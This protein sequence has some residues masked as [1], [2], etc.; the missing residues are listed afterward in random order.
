MA[1]SNAIRMGKA[2]V[3]IHGELNP[4]KKDLKGGEGLLKGFGEKVSRIGETLAKAGGAALGVEGIVGLLE[5]LNTGA[6]SG[7]TLLR[8]AQSTGLT[9]EALGEL[10][11]AAKEAGLDMETVASSVDK[12]QKF[13]VEGAKGS[14]ESN[15]ALNQLRLTIGQLATLSPDKQF[16]LIGERLRQIKDPALRDATAMQIFGKSGADIIPIFARGTEQL[17]EWREEAIEMG[18][19]TTEQA[20][21]SREFT[22][23]L[24]KMWASINRVSSALA[25]ALLPDVKDLA[26]GVQRAAKWIGDLIDDNKELIGTAAKVGMA[27]LLAGGAIMFVGSAVGTVSSVIAG[28]GAV[29]TFAFGVLSAV[30]AAVLSPIGTLITWFTLM[31]L[32]FLTSTGA[33]GA[34]VEW[35]CDRWHDMEADFGAAWGGIVAAVKKGDL[36]AAMAVVSALI[37]YELGR[38]FVALDNRWIEFKYSMIAAA[39]EMG[40]GIVNAFIE[41]FGQVEKAWNAVEATILNGVL[42]AVAMIEKKG[43][44]SPVESGAIDMMT[45]MGRGLNDAKVDAD[46]NRR[47]AIAGAALGGVAAAL[48]GEDDKKRELDLNDMVLKALKMK[49]GFAIG[50][51]MADDKKPHPKEK[52][53]PTPDRLSQLAAGDKHGGIGAVDARTN[54]GFKVVAAALRK[55]DDPQVQAAK[56]LAQ[57]AKNQNQRDN[58]MQQTR[59]AVVNLRVLKF[60]G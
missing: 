34:A 24:E 48:P 36:G 17:R 9:V 7:A 2:Y 42:K 28:I 39:F 19:K 47:K 30:I 23:S 46:T 33:I 10:G 59:D 22:L 26:D 57:L 11:F 5:K 18:R 49:L 4:L 51:A 16:E 50:A 41:A 52:E 40:K 13:L 6:E 53:L 25:R 37:E 35:L 20:E 43:M 60:P 56:S 8:L 54:E 21:K 3:E 45:G 38:A 32:A 29:S 55:S 27:L 14:K 12:M 58:W 1:D 31:S 44:L 15:F